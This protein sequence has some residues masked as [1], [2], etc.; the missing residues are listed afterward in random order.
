MEREKEGTGL[1]EIKLKTHGGLALLEK[2]LNGRA[3]ISVESQPAE[4]E[5]PLGAKAGLDA[6]S[7]PGS[8]QNDPSPPLQRAVSHLR[9]SPLSL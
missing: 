2:K 7:P 1:N 6:G 5:N 4:V 9:E 3:P 8:H